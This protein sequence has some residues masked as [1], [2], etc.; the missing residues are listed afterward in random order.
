MTDLRESFRALSAEALEKTQPEFCGWQT[1]RLQNS[2]KARK[3][4]FR[5]ESKPSPR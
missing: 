5:N 3:E 2:R 4:I 1:R